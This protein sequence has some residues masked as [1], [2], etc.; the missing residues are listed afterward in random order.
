MTTISYLNGSLCSDSRFTSGGI[1]VDK[2]SKVFKLA[3]GRL[4]AGAG[5]WSEIYAVYEWLNGDQDKPEKAENFEGLI[6]ECD[7]SAWIIDEDLLIAPQSSP[8]ALG[9]GRD[10]ALTAMMLGKTAYEAI[11]V[12]CGMDV[13]SG[14]PV[15]EMRIDEGTGGA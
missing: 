14:L 7:G 6:V 9:S 3:D 10:I 2:R 15:N 13:H 1:I 4:F 11:E 12:A 5:H 8:C